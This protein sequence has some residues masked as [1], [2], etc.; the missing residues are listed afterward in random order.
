MQVHHLV[1]FHSQIMS[2]LLKVGNL[3]KVAASQ[4]LA[5]VGVVI[6]GAEVCAGELNANPGCYSHLQ[7]H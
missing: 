4:S 5:D 7:K 2:S 1:V 3:H 6:P